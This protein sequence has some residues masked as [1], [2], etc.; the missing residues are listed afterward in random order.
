MFLRLV[1]LSVNVTVPQIGKEEHMHSS[2]PVSEQIC[3]SKAA[4]TAEAGM[5]NAEIDSLTS[6]QTI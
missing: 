6:Y 4:D 2:T 3:V 5:I 1:L